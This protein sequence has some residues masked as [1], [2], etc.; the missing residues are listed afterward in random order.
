[1]NEWKL[2]RKASG[3]RRTCSISKFW[4]VYVLYLCWKSIILIMKTYLP[5]F[6]LYNAIFIT[7]GLLYFNLNFYNL[8]AHIIAKFLRK[9]CLLKTLL[10]NMILMGRTFEC[11][12]T[13]LSGALKNKAT[14]Y[15]K[16]KNK[17]YTK[18]SSFHLS[19][20]FSLSRQFHPHIF[21]QNSWH[22]GLVRCQRSKWLT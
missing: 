19:A 5:C 11:M 16:Y 3:G 22:V 1:M 20:A 7:I 8:L 21:Y 10:N 13:F 12:C 2:I 18:H 6:I 15:I 4:C 14:I 17:K 9:G